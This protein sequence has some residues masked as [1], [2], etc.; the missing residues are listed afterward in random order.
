MLDEFTLSLQQAEDVLGLLDLRGP[1]QVAQVR[2]YNH[3]YRLVCAGQTFYL[4]VHTKDWYPQDDAETGYSARHEASAWKILADHGLAAPEV[5][6]V[7]VGRSNPVGRS[8]LLTREVQGEP[9]QQLFKRA[10]PQ[11]IQEMLYAVGAYLRQMHTIHFRYPG[12]IIDDGPAAPPHEDQWQ[13]FIWSLTTRQQETRTWIQAHSNELSAPLL[14]Q[15]EA[16]IDEMPEY[17]YLDY[18]K[19]RFTQGDFKADQILMRQQDTHWQVAAVL[20]MEVASAGDCLSDVVA[21]CLAAAQCLTTES[22]WW[23]DLFAGYGHE[24]DFKAFILR[25]LVGWYPYQANIW[26]GTGESG[27]NHLLHSNN[28]SELF[29]HAHLT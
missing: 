25:A 28:W 24:P 26:P 2:D 10:T 9:L 6:L 7:G 15:L 20:D 17:L 27:F 18:T 11:Q 1:V 4:K 21:F 13:H 14:T 16:C 8:F 5:M 3:T 12:Y 29:A 22:N 19:P 23:L